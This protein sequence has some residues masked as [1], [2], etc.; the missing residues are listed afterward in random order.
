MNPRFVDWLKTV[1][2]LNRKD[3]A[4]WAYNRYPDLGGGA[5]RCSCSGRRASGK[6]LAEPVWV[7]LLT[8]EIRAFSRERMISCADWLVF[9]D[10]LVYDSPCLITER[11]AIAISPER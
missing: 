7:D 3:T 2:E 1:P 11:A 8:G 6:P 9:T 10:V 5:R 4:L